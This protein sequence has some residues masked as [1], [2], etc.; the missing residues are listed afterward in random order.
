[1][2]LTHLLFVDDVI[3]FGLDTFDEWRAFDVLLDTFCAASGMC[4]SLE[5][6]G[7]LFNDLELEV[8]TSIQCFL[9]YK[10]DP[11][12]NGFK[13]L[14]YYIKPLGYLVKDWWWLIRNF[15]KRIMHWAHKLLSLSGRPVLIRVV[16]TS[17]LVYWFAL[18]PVPKSILKKLRQ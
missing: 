5:K 15:E 4:I 12:S 1:M 11:I 9:P 14:G 13:Y 17:L 3:L 7:F 8:Q 18:A 6:S 10:M 2:T 16:L